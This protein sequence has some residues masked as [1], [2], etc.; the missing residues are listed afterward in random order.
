VAALDITVRQA[1]VD[2]A[3]AVAR[4]INEVILGGSPS[5]L[6]TPFSDEDERTYI[7]SLPAR[8]FIHVAELP[9]GEVIGTQ[10]IAPAADFTTRELDHV[11]TMGTWIDARYRRRGVGRRLAEASFAA[12]RA[13]GYEKVFTDVRDDNLD[14]LVFHVSLGFRLA[15]TA[16]RHAKAGERYYDVWLIE[17]F[18]T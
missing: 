13:L 10:T 8:A 14:S 12:A 3:A 7:E 16:K 6:D 15:G 5:L 2:D 18:L 1:T 4:L 17:R 9:A 11:A